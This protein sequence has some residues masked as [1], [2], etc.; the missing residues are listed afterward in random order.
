MSNNTAKHSHFLRPRRRKVK[1]HQQEG[2]LVD[3]E[4]MNQR[5]EEFIRHTRCANK[6]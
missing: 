3:A 4:Y 5:R 2:L 6:T 1:V